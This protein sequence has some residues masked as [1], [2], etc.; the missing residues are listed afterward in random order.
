V[1]GPEEKPT[2]IKGYW[3]DRYIGQPDPVLLESPGLVPAPSG[4]AMAWGTGT[5]NGPVVSVDALVTLIDDIRRKGQLLAVQWLTVNRH[6]LMTDFTPSWHTAHDVEWEIEFKWTSQGE[7]QSDMVLVST[8]QDV[9]EVAQTAVSNAIALRQSAVTSFPRASDFTDAINTKLDGVRSTVAALLGAAQG[10]ADGSLGAIDTAR[11]AVSLLTY[12]AVAAQDAIAEV[13][14]R[15]DENCY[16]L[17][18]D[19]RDSQATLGQVTRAAQS[20]RRITRQA[21]V[22]LHDS[23]RARRRM[24]AMVS[25]DISVAV[26]ARQDQDLREIAAQQY[27]DAGAWRSLAAHNGLRGSKL[28]AGQ[29]VMVPRARAG[30]GQR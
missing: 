1:L 4:Y 27:G 26:Q 3:H 2:T 13:Y 9:T 24:A 16:G 29:I 18:G 19:I 17:K 14:A 11:R 7:V 5:A 25:P 15:C 20:N 10:A 21:R 6:G 12:T 28:R 8:D 30:A 23:A 22:V